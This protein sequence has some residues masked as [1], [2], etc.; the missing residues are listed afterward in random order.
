MTPRPLLLLSRD[1]SL[2]GRKRLSV[3]SHS[4]NRLCTIMIPRA[5]CCSGTITVIVVPI[6]RN[7]KRLIPAGM[8]M[9]LSLSM[10]VFMIATVKRSYFLCWVL[11]SIRHYQSHNSRRS[12][13]N[14]HYSPAYPVHPDLD[15]SWDYCPTGYPREKYLVCQRMWWFVLLR[16]CGC[17]SGPQ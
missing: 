12:E 11:V 13:K 7:C 1:N 8:C 17:L 2:S 5:R 10:T 15:C 14:H 4:A 3:C 9:P 6:A 16:A